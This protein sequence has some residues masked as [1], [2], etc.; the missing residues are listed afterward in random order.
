M[1]PPR[2]AEVYPGRLPGSVGS[3]AAP[4]AGAG[5]GAGAGDF[6]NQVPTGT[7]DL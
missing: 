7:T 2:Q 6:R 5:A 4:R 3:L 1:H